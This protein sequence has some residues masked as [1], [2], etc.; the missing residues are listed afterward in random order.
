M[1]RISDMPLEFYISNLAGLSWVL[2]A[3]LFLLIWLLYSTL[4]GI[5][6]EFG[7]LINSSIRLP[8]YVQSFLPFACHLV[9]GERCGQLGI[10]CSN[11]YAWF[12]LSQNRCAYVVK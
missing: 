2:W 4:D 1:W 10:R 6:C 5:I 7:G 11:S 8:A 12:G 3:C 9:A